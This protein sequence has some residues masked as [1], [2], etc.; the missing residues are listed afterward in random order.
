MYS[1]KCSKDNT[2]LRHEQEWERSHVVDVMFS[3]EK[4]CASNIELSESRKRETI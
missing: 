2:T 4:N 1:V 3:K